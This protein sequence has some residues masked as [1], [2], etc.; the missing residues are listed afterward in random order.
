M[1]IHEIEGNNTNLSMTLSRRG[2]YELPREDAVNFF[3]R[4][5]KLQKLEIRGSNS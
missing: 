3:G 1:K 5:D 4:H 2:R